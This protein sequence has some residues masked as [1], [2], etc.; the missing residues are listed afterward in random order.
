MKIPLGNAALAATA[1]RS[2]MLCRRWSLSATW[3]AFGG[4]SPSRS[5]RRRPVPGSQPRLGARP[6]PCLGGSPSL[7]PIIASRAQVPGSQITAKQACPFLFET[8]SAP[9]SSASRLSLNPAPLQGLIMEPPPVSAP[10]PGSSRLAAPFPMHAANA[11]AGMADSRVCAWLR[12][13]NGSGS[14]MPS[15][16]IQDSG[17]HRNAPQHAASIRCS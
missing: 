17:S 13:A 6:R 1:E 16:G 5:R 9:I 3:M 7:P 10:I 2:F 4:T 15:P 11:K 12:P 14:P 8:P